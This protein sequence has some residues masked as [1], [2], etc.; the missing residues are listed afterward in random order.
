LLNDRTDERRCLE[1]ALE[2]F[3][4]E[5]D[6]G[7]A[8]H[9]EIALG[10]SALERNDVER[11]TALAA[12][13]E[14]AARTLDDKVL[15]AA[16]LRLRGGL[17][18]DAGDYERAR[19]Y[20]ERELAIWRERGHGPMVA[21]CLANLGW[22]ELLD[23]RYDV[24]RK[25]SSEALDAGLGRDPELR[26]VASSNLG[27]AE[28][29]QGDAPL[30]CAHFAT[31]LELGHNLRAQLVVAE[32]ALGVAGASAA[33]RPDDAVRLWA[34]ALAV[35]DS[36]DVGLTPVERRMEDRFLKPI[37]ARLDPARA[38]ALLAEG[39]RLGFRELADEALAVASA[40]AARS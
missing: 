33:E 37:H 17:L 10:W 27:L 22:L 23:G 6:L 3:E 31:A 40:P 28:L 13:A 11:A 21:A 25:L 5:G 12:R 14:A 9:A 16:S 35:H 2:Y 26:A 4:A 24:A 36:C 8:T 15:V 34:G 18:Q 19:P 32:A 1:E 38:D 30:A 39:K 20:H 7:G 29:L